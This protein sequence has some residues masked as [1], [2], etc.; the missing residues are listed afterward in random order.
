MPV[1]SNSSRNSRYVSTTANPRGLGNLARGIRTAPASLQNVGTM[2][3]PATQKYLVDIVRTADAEALIAVLKNSKLA[4]KMLNTTRLTEKYHQAGNK[5]LLHFALEQYV[6][7]PT[8]KKKQV[9]MMLEKRIAQLNEEK[10][11][12]G[13]KTRIM[14]FSKDDEGRHLL[15][16]FALHR[17]LLKPEQKVWLDR[18]LMKHIEPLGAQG[19]TSL[20]HALKTPTAYSGNYHTVRNIL[21]DKGYHENAQNYTPVSAKNKNTGQIVHVSPLNQRSH[22]ARAR[23]MMPNGK[24]PLFKP[25]TRGSTPTPSIS[26]F[27]RRFNRFEINSNNN[28]NVVNTAASGRAKQT[29]TKGGTETRSTRQKQT[30]NNSQMEVNK[31]LLYKNINKRLDELNKEVQRNNLRESLYT[32]ILNMAQELHNT[33]ERNMHLTNIQKRALQLKAIR[34]RN[35]ANKKIQ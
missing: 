34:I 22:N 5:T 33:V 23:I 16:T 30:V 9:F 8:E 27:G 15:H 17:T 20:E 28:N 26:S 18:R 13:V 6:K 1:R 21:H 19:I 11:K 3:V 24:T 2:N 31:L 10:M 25:H 35:T 12:K 29:R 4:D 7:D 32:G 14:P